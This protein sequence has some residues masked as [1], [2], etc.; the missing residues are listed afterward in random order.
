[1]LQYS[2]KLSPFMQNSCNGSLTAV[3]FSECSSNTANKNARQRKIASSKN[4]LTGWEKVF[5][6]IKIQIFLSE[7]EVEQKSFF[8]IISFKEA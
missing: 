1:M 4:A 8:L 3:Q 7:N 6:G 5:F 2:E